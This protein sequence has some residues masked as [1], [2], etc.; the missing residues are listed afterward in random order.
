MN[1]NEKRTDTDDGA[2]SVETKGMDAGRIVDLWQRTIETLQLI[3][4]RLETLEGLLTKI[5]EQGVRDYP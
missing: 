2:R 1:A 3:E 5:H 4:R